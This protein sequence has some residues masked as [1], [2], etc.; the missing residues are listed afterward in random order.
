[1]YYYFKRTWHIGRGKGSKNVAFYIIAVVALIAVYTLGLIFMK[2]I[3]K[4]RRFFD[5]DFPFIIFI[6]YIIELLLLVLDVGFENWSF[7]NALPLG[8]VGP[9]MFF[10]LPFL[11]LLPKKARRYYHTLV[12]LLSPAML[13]AGL[14]CGILLAAAGRPFFSNYLLDMICH[15][16]FALYGIYL[17]RSEQ[18]DFDIPRNLISGGVILVVALLM[19]VLNAILHTSFFGL[20]VYGEHTIYNILF[21]KSGALST[22]LYFIGLTVMLTIGYFFQK[23][24]LLAHNA[25]FATSQEMDEETT[26]EE[27]K[28]ESDS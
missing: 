24:L 23:Y 1:M 5:V 3:V 14:L 18:V 11:F 17:V 27:V 16:L 10:T 4:F 13:I 2:H 19:L 21:L 8:N 7:F 28:D 6:L 20:N 15:V 12:A 26:V 22:I 25:L 9:F